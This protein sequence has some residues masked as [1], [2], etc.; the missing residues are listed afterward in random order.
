MSCVTTSADAPRLVTSFSDER[1]NGGLM[2]QIEIRGRFVKQQNRRLPWRRPAPARP[3][4]VRRLT[5]R[6]S[7]GRA[8]SSSCV[9]RKHLARDV[10]VARSFPTPARGA[11]PG[12]AATED[13]LKNSH[14]KTQVGFLRDHR[15]PLRDCAPR[16]RQRVAANRARF[17]R[18]IMPNRRSVCAGSSTCRRHL[19]R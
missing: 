11:G 9:S 12:V 2:R 5:V 15:D 10:N 19:V 16:I 1:Q 7:S 4:G 17:L 8:N 6:S 13:K 14:G 18:T 3:A